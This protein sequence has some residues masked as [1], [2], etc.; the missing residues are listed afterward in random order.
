MVKYVNENLLN[1]IK[2]ND[3]YPQD[4]DHSK[5]IYLHF[6]KVGLYVIKYNPKNIVSKHINFWQ[7]KTADEINKE[8]AGKEWIEL[9]EKEWF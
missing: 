9:A 6:G 1:V 8:F 4:V 2:N 3:I 7:D 5:N